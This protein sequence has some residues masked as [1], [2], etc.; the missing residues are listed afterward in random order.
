MRYFLVLD[1]VGT[2]ANPT[3]DPSEKSPSSEMKAQ[4]ISFIYLFIYLPYVNFAI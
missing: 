1:S 4:V 2:L 3:T